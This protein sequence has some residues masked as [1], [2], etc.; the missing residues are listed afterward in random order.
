MRSPSRSHKRRAR[1][2]T[3]VIAGSVLIWIASGASVARC[4]E[5][6]FISYGGGTVLGTCTTSSYDQTCPDPNPLCYCASSTGNVSGA[7]GYGYAQVDMD[8]NFNATAG[9]FPFN[10]SLFVVG[11][12]NVEQ[13][14]FSGSYCEKN[15]DR[16]ENFEGTYEIVRSAEGRT[17]S[18]KVSGVSTANKFVLHFIEEK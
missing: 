5:T 17:A 15:H 6:T 3:M 7:T 13:V 4:G 2:R 8:H 14:D 16:R 1:L 11:D 10:A 9:C 12:K 18:G